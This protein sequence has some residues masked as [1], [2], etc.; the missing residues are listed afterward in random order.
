MP[1]LTSVMIMH[2]VCCLISQIWV[3]TKRMHKL[4]STQAWLY[5]QSL[6][7]QWCLWRLFKKGRSSS[8]S[9]LQ[10]FP[11]AGITT[12]GDNFWEHGPSCGYVQTIALLEATERP[13]VVPRAGRFPHRVIALCAFSASSAQGTL[14]RRGCCV[15]FGEGMD[16]TFCS[17]PAGWSKSQKRGFLCH[18]FRSAIQSR[19]VKRAV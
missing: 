3:C 2:K 17:K 12:A 19:R 13:P 11:R 6:G 14:S 7:V 18:T 10:A 1:R 8:H 4:S 15:L 16:T 5:W 9:V